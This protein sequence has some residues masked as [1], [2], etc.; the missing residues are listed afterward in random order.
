[1]VEKKGVMNNFAIN[2]VKRMN[3]DEIKAWYENPNSENVGR[4]SIK[5]LGR[6]TGYGISKQ[7]P[8]TSPRYGAKIVLIKMPDGS[9][10]LLTSYPE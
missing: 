4:F 8:T 9:V 2:D 1:M 6:E 10:Q 5:D 7:N 3:A